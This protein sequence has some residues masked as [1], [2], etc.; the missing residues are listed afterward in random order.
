M[1]AGD[2]VQLEV[3]VLPAEAFELRV[4]L[5]MFVEQVTS[6]DHVLDSSGFCLL[7]DVLESLIALRVLSPE[8]YIPCYGYL[9]FESLVRGRCTRCGTK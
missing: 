3:R 1:I 7:E 4:V 8:M 9:H 5:K 6:D 2:D